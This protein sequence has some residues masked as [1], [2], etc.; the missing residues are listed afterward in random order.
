MP[1]FSGTPQFKESPVRRT[2]FDFAIESVNICLTRCV[3]LCGL[4]H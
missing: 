2:F 3:A 1:V 4:P